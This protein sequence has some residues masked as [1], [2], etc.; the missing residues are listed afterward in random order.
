MATITIANKVRIVLEN[1]DFAGNPL[2]LDL[3][4]G[5]AL[6]LFENPLSSFVIH[7]ELSG[8]DA[9]WRRI[10]GMAARILV[11]TCA[12]FEK[13]IQEVLGCNQLF[14]EKA[15]RLFDGQGLSSLGRE[16]DPKFCFNAENAFLQSPRISDYPRPLG[17]KGLL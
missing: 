8:R 6:E 5:I 11:V 16:D 13:D 17:I 4:L 3:L 12:V 10:L 15:N 7:N 9:F 1:G 2:F 14:K